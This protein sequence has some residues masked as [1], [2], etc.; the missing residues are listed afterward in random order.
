[1]T[2]TGPLFSFRTEWEP[3]ARVTASPP[4]GGRGTTCFVAGCTSGGRAA[5]LRATKGD[6]AYARPDPLRPVLLERGGPAPGP[7]LTWA[8][9]DVVSNPPDP[10][11]RQNLPPCACIT[12]PGPGTVTISGTPCPPPHDRG[13][14]AL[15]SNPPDAGGGG[16][17]WP[18]RPENPA[19]NACPAKP[20]LPPVPRPPA[21]RCPANPQPRPSF[22]PQPA[23]RG[24]SGLGRGLVVPCR[25]LGGEYR[26]PWRPPET[27]S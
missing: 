3:V 16:R 17:P 1:V 13:L 18:N 12:C 8:L 27:W 14:P 11:H 7:G 20:P 21:T 2:R 23:L 15:E 5:A 24:R 19:L 9:A 6:S 26:L 22:R 10:R 4:V 25:G